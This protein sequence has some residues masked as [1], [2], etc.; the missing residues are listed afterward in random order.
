MEH[1]DLAQLASVIGAAGCALVLLARGRL[2]LL[3]GF[4]LLGAAEALLVYSLI[5]ARD[6]R[7]LVTTPARV[8]LIVVLGLVVV[9]AAV[10]LARFPAFVPVLVLAAAPFRAP[11]ELGDQEAFLLVP[12]Y[13]VIGASVLALVVRVGR[14]GELPELPRALTWPAAAL[15]ILVALSLIWSQDLRAG[16]IELLFF[17]FPFVGLVAVVARSPLAEWLP[18]A[19]ATTV[20]LLALVFAGIGIWQLWSERLFFARDLEVAN[21][22]TSYFRTT[23]LF[24]DSSLYSRHLDLAIVVLVAALWL[25]RLDLRLGVPLI[26]ALWTGL[27]FSYSQSSMAALVVAVLAVS[28]VAAGR[29]ARRILLVGSAVFVLGSAGLVA[30]TVQGD[31]AQRFTSGRSS[32]LESTARVFADHPLVGVGVGAQPK[33]SREE[34][35]GRRETRRNASHTTP[36]T[37][38]AELGVVG[39][40]AYLGFLAG[41]ARLLASARRRRPAFGLGLA[42]A[43]LLLVVHSLSYSGFFQDPIAW[44]ALAVAAA[45]LAPARRPSES[46]AT[47]LREPSPPA[48][49]VP[50]ATGAAPPVRGRWQT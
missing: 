6:L 32:L 40:A 41:A 10:L 9:A 49:L 1:G 38:A 14:G 34:P 42:A 21:A 46:P 43:F 15:A 5:P 16:T 35:G 30:T 29:T 44:G 45:S 8:A 37:V 48:A 12:L 24:A 18:K 20:V 33:A 25:R 13:A 3:G 47:A 36:L 19:L 11:V 50:G 7:L 31:S 17:L 2:P 26:A 23:S 22:Y 27:Y 28:L 39:L 4:G